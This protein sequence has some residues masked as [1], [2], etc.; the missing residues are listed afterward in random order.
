MPPLDNETKRQMSMWIES[1]FR[2]RGRVTGAEIVG[3]FL[4]FSVDT[5]MDVDVMTAE[6]RA[7][8]LALM[9]PAGADI[10]VMKAPGG[11][12]VKVKPRQG[13]FS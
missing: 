7:Q 10:H 8:M 2:G 11:A 4:W 5:K 13:E 1:G 12:V 3:A 9:G 6:E